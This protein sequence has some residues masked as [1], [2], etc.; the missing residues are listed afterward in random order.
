MKKLYVEIADNP[1]KREYGLMDRK[2]MAKNCGMF[3]K[4]ASPRY[5]SFWM[6]NTYIPLDIAFVNDEGK[7]LEIKELIPLSTRAITSR[8][9]C[10]YALEVN[11]GWF[12]ENGIKEGSYIL[13][14]NIKEHGLGKKAQIAIE[15]VPVEVPEEIPT[16]PEIAQQP[17]PDI[18]LNLSFKDILRDADLNRIDLVIIY[19]TKYGTILSPKVISPPFTFE[20]DAD[21]VHDAIVK[22]WDN[23]TGGWK[24]FLIDNIID[25][26]EKEQ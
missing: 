18:A 13:G 15:E 22:A 3:F 4:F 2:K 11:K 25:L 17:S 21:G 19:E 6:K 9:L 7:I 26:E 16:A 20:P 5:L 1:I 10:R 24:S 23:Q 8:E 14:K 12:R